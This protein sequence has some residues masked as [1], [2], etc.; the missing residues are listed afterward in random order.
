MV[1][2]NLNRSGGF[3]GWL[4]A[5]AGEMTISRTDTVVGEHFTAA[6]SRPRLS[7]E[8]ELDSFPSV[9]AL[10]L[11]TQRCSGLIAAMHHAIFAPA[12]ARDPI[13]DSVAI[14]VGPF[15]QLRVA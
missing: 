11:Q 2:R 9:A 6:S 7:A 12:V 1:R 10:S 4:S 14:P 5:L 13:D 3:H 15:Q 8:I